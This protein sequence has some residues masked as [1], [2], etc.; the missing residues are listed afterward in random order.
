MNNQTATSSPNGTKKQRKKQAKQEA[1]AM[2]K[3]EQAKKNEQKAAKKV[4]K[5]Q[6]QLE[7]YRT[8]IHTIE[9]RLAEIRTPH[10]DEPARDTQGA[11]QNGQEVSQGSSENYATMSHSSD[12]EA[13]SSSEG[14][15]HTDTA[16]ERETN[17]PG[18]G[19]AYSPEHS[20]EK[21]PFAE[22]GQ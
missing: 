9:A 5:A 2:L 3:L 18:D 8:E 10:D 22:E 15:G 19:D 14:E 16:H 21:S 11:S 20:D 12:N 13:T 6:A 17:P 1:K 7:A 4:T